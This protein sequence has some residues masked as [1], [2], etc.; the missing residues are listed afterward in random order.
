MSESLSPVGRS[1][2]C[3]GKLISQLRK[4]IGW[5]QS[6]LARR[7]GFTE[8]L[9][10]KAEASQNIA[11]STLCIIAE[12]LS[13][14]GAAVSSQELSVDP[15]ALAREF[16]LSMYQRE[17]NVIDV[18]EHF[19]SPDVVLHF[20][21]DPSVFPF[22]GSHVG[23]EA[24]RRAFALFYSVIEPPEDH[25]EIEN[26]QFVSTG[27]GA[28]VWGET[29]AHPVGMPMPGP[30]KLAIKM[31]FK[32]GKLVSFDDRFDTQEG[33]NHFAEASKSVLEE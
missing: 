27:H 26:F 32:N 18:N 30:I 23:I 11:A 24:A 17:R 3:N 28:L 15:A 25:S 19:I 9:I 6:D 10:V 22:A 12:T 5:T 20:A 21:G 16:I 13:E 14:G 2:P 1:M 7:A 4:K 31:D 33:A 29:W 8:R